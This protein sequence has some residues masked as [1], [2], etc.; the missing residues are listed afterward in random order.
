MTPAAS[1][2]DA[3]RLRSFI[4]QVYEADNVKGED[5][6]P[7]S[8]S[9]HGYRKD[10]GEALLKLVV[11]EAAV[12]TIET[13]FCLGLS[14]LFI[15]EGLLSSGDQSARHISIDPFQKTWK[16]AG[17]RTVRDAGIESIVDYRDAPSQVVLPA[18][19]DQHSNQFD[20]ALIDGDHRF[21]GA[22]IDLFYM[23]H[24]VKP[25]GVI[26]VDDVWMPAVA[27][28]TGYFVTNLGF[29]IVPNSFPGPAYEGPPNNF[30]DRITTRPPSATAVIRRPQKPPGRP[31]WDG[32]QQEI[33]AFKE[34]LWR[35]RLPNDAERVA[36]RALR[37]MERL[38]SRLR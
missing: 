23:Q 38:K 37:E 34:W 14:T 33:S 9:P 2:G 27:V 26:V 30:L 12:R 36:R 28:A 29:E 20:L 3:E 4:S 21:E 8:L 6:T 32:G 19:L 5:G 25:G 24:L 35:S 11:D 16:H 31:W 17:V 10:D 1:S 22:F 15:C 13:G 7:I 18:L